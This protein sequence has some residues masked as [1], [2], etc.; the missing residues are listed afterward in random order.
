MQG[1]DTLMQSEASLGDGD[2][3]MQGTAAGKPTTLGPSGGWSP[4]GVCM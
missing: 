1:I 3:A 2:V 4:V